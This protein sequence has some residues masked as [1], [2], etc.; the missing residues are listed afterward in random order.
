MM[1]DMK[2]KPQFQPSSE[3]DVKAVVDAKRNTPVN[4]VERAKA[5]FRPNLGTSTNTPPIRAPGMPI[6]AM[7]S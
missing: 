3:F 4:T 6:A 5:P 7:I 1:F 2:L